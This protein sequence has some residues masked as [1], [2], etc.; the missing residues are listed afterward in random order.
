MKELRCQELKDSVNIMIKVMIIEDEPL[1]ARNCANY[2]CTYGHYVT[3]SAICSTAPEAREAFI[4]IPPDVIF[5]D[6][7][8][9][10]DDGLTLAQEFRDKGWTGKLII[11]SVYNSFEFAKKAI[12]LDV[13]DYLLK[14]IFPED[15]NRLLDK[16]ILDIETG[17]SGIESRLIK[18]N[19][20]SFP[21]YIIKA[22][23]YISLYYVQQISLKA[24]ADF[25]GV[26]SA[27][28]SAG[29]KKYT[30]LTFV[31]Y[32]NMYRLEV[33][34]KLLDDSI[35]PL[36]EIANQV[37]IPDVVYFNKLF[38]RFI[39]ISPGRYRKS[40]IETVTT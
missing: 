27:Y 21:Q 28:L 13:E 33:A 9:G 38:K 31:E 26:S 3:V 30:G 17:D 2:V 29:F 20:S 19:R 34:K 40:I 12:H 37:G 6:I 1:A 24:I 35:Y 36:D 32:L 5:T 7:R 4:K 39:G 22:L 14:P 16:I 10:K 8:L 11:M 25:S 15:V 23:D 18:N